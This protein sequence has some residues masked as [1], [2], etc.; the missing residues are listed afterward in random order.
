[1][2][3]NIA[4][5]LVLFLPC[6]AIAN[7]K[8]IEYS[9]SPVNIN[10][11]V[12]AHGAKKIVD[13]LYKSNA[14]WTHLMKQISTGEKAWLEV[15]V[16][17]RPGADAGAASM[18]EESVGLALLSNP[19]NVLVFAIPTYKLQIVCGGRA[20]PLPTYELSISEIEQQIKSV[21][22]VKDPQL[23]TLR[24]SCLAELETSKVH[25]RRFFDIK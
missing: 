18:L 2:R 5:I 15:A 12:K 14:S 8:I 19:A 20:D 7:D 25:L 4:L 21:Q 3:T 24:D 16:A 10:S 23:L 6:S 13:E 17:L 9:T 22:A 1:M 11:Q